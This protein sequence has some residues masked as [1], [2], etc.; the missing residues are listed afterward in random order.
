MARDMAKNLA[1]YLNFFWAGVARQTQTGAIFPSQRYLIEKMIAPIPANYRGVIAELGA[2]TGALT[3][4]LATRCP[5]A[6][7]LAC[8]INP[9]LAKDLRHN[10]DRAGING[11]V[12]VVRDAAEHVLSDLT[13]KKGKQLDYI[14]S[15]IPLGNTSR[16]KTVALLECIGKTLNRGGL[17]IQFQH[18]LLD[19]RNI[20]S[21]FPTV[22]T[23]PVLLNFPPAFVYYARK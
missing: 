5:G 13:K 10:L 16:S 17:Y 14:I 11:Q 18:S 2:G 19:R 22:R 12:Q 8:E 23:V 1:G 15:G 20:R 7:I 6:K 3:I 21:M 9:V 4:R